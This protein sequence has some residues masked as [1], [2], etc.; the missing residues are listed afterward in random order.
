MPL[1][2][3]DNSAIDKFNRCK[4]QA[5]L[6]EKEVTNDGGIMVSD[7]AWHLRDWLLSDP[8]V[9]QAAKD[10]V[11]SWKT[12]LPCQELFVYRDVR[13]RKRLIVTLSCSV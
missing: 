13:A 1:T 11:R 6:L 12:P 4:H 3:D 5:V 9:P 7:Y 2:F 10:E 8:S